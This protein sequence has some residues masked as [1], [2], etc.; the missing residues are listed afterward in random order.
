MVSDTHQLWTADDIA[1]LR[2]MHA[3]SES[4]AAISDALGRT[5]SSIKQ[6]VQ[7]YIRDRTDRTR[8]DSL[9]LYP[10][11]RVIY[12]ALAKVAKKGQPCPKNDALGAFLNRGRHTGANMLVRLEAV[13]V[14]EIRRHANHRAV[15]IVATGD[16]TEGYDSHVISPA[17]NVVRIEPRPEPTQAPVFR[18]PCPGCGVR[19]DA[20]PALCCAR[21]RALR[22]L[23]A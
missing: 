22:R 8:R 3:D 17:R 19:L 7:R 12:N 20:D 1:T 23:V 9:G 6:A 4:H 11:E 14:I 21:G 13:G 18:D 15:R 16:K 10:D 2:T 5:K